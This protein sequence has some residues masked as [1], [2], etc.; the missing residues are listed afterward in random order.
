MNDTTNV[1]TSEF[2]CPKCQG[3]L[4]AGWIS[5]FTDDGLTMYW[6]VEAPEGRKRWFGWRDSRSLEPMKIT[7]M[8]GDG[9]RTGYRCQECQL[10]LFSYKNE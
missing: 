1:K 3:V 9:E 5:F 8:T 6:A 4:E 2:R 7:G 10:M